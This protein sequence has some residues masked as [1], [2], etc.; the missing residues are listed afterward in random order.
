M[1]KR[2][3][4]TEK[5]KKK[6]VRSLDPQLKLF[7]VYL[8]DVCNHAGIWDVDIELVNFVLKTTLIEDEVIKVFGDKIELLDGGRKWYIPSFI[9]F[10]YNNELN[11]GNKV[12]KSVL[13]LLN[14]EG[15]YKGLVRGMQAS[16]DKDKDKI[17]D[18]VK[19]KQYKPDFQEVWDKYPSKDGRKAAERHFEATVCTEEDFININKALNN[20]LIHLKTNDWKKPKNGST[21][22]NNW[23]DWVDWKEPEGEKDAINRKIFREE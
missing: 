1:P 15:A 5:W 3:T 20:Y 8:L 11:P 12:H 7:W 13:N 10:Q 4:D 2:F 17:K 18:K 19:E 9:D 21:W 22:F 14:K 6:W 16:K 23:K